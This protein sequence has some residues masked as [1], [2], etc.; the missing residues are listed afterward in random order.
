MKRISF[1]LCAILMPCVSFADDID[2][3]SNELVLNI[4]RI[5]LELSKTQI[6]HAADYQNSPI[7]ALNA[8]GQDLVKGIFD[9]VLEYNHN[10]FSWDN[11]LFME[12]GKTTLRPYDAPKTTSENADKILVSSN[13]SYAC[14]DFDSF[15]L[16][17]TVRAAYETEFEP[18]KGTDDRLKI[19]RGTGGISLFDN[20]VIKSLY[21]AAVYEYDFTYGHDQ[22]SKLAAEVG[23]RLEYAVREGVKLSTDGYYREYLD[24]SRYV[25]TD[26]K[27][28]LSLAARM[29]TNLWGDFTLGPYV[30]YRRAKARDAEYYGSNFML[31]VSF[32]YITKFGLD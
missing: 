2:L 25:G 22:V 29:D 14:W 28:D 12:Y 18:A 15:K 8:D 20:P 27:R 24:Y 6:R 5:G 3:E 4:R 21:V 31:G 7:S 10:R 16:G 30:Q 26:L 23:W 19:M 17:P 11:G 13:L 1:L 9:T 32:N